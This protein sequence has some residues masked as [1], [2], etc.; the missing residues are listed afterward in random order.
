MNNDDF[1]NNVNNVNK[2]NVRTD[3]AYDEVTRNKDY[4]MPDFFES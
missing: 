1:N 4:D 2:W 3:L